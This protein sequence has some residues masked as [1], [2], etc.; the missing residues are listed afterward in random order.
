MSSEQDAVSTPHGEETAK[1]KR[2][3]CIAKKLCMSSKQD[4][5]STPHGGETVQCKQDVYG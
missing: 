4:T 3:V 2:D 5:V 1:C